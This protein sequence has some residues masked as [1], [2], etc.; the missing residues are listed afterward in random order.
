MQTVPN[1]VQ[2]PILV[3]QIMFPLPD[4][5]SV[6]SEVYFS[7]ERNASVLQNPTLNIPHYR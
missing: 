4:F 5:V 3:T 1:F 7:T 2:A 6:V